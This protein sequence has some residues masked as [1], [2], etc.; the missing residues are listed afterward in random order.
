VRGYEK[1]KLAN[2]ERYRQQL[3]ELGIVGA[4]AAEDA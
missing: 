4:A 1:I 2:V 3:A